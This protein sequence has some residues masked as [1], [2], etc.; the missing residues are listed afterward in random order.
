MTVTVY[1]ELVENKGLA[2]LR[3]DIVSDTIVSPAEGRLLQE[4]LR[5]FYTSDEDYK[6]VHAFNHTPA[7]FDFTTLLKKL[8]HKV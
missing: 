3:G 7:S 5:A 2:L 6:M 8:G 1:S 4:L